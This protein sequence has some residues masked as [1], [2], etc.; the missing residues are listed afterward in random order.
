MAA[1]WFP[2]SMNPPNFFDVPV[3]DGTVHPE[4]LAKWSPIRRWRLRI[5][6]SQICK[7][8]APLC[9]MMDVGLQDKTKVLPFFS[10]NLDFLAGQGSR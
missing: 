2:D 7:D 4:I 1:A 5:N 3:A 6:A 10:E 8:L 9:I